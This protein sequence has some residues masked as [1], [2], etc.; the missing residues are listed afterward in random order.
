MYG[1][2]QSNNSSIHSQRRR[3]VVDIVARA[4]NVSRGIVVRTS[5]S[6][7][8]L[9]RGSTTHLDV[10]NGQ[11]DLATELLEPYNAERRFD[12]AGRRHTR[13]A[14]GATSLTDGPLLER[15]KNVFP[16]LCAERSGH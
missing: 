1:G 6:Q 8:Y 9:S 5:V 11:V 2:A 7:H 15:L 16:A 13:Q 14:T 3:R 4:V 12:F 10:I